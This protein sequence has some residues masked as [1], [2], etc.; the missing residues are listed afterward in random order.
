M[1]KVFEILHRTGSDW[2]E[3]ARSLFARIELMT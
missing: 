2:R 3:T 1:S